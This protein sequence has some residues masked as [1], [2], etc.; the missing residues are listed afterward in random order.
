MKHICFD[1]FWG[2]VKEPQ[3]KVYIVF[4]LK[5][6]KSYEHASKDRNDLLA[7]HRTKC[8]RHEEKKTT[9]CK[10]KVSAHR[11]HRDRHRHS[12]GHLT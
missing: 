3:S 6:D 10:R 1:V 11:R 2:T 5:V 12:H 8:S 9:W 4:D 7:Q